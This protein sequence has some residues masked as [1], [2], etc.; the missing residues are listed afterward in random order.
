MEPRFPSPEAAAMYGFPPAYCRVVAS[1]MHG[2]YAYVLLDTRIHEAPYLYGV[3][4]RR[5]QAGWSELGSSNGS[6]W[7]EEGGFLYFW[8]EAPTGADRVRVTFRGAEVEQEV[9][10]RAFLVVWWD[11]PELSDEWPWV[12]AFRFGGEWRNVGTGW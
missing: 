10:G 5:D 12:V 1:T 4:C 3:T 6:G 11:V 7:T 9:S 8:D 2:D